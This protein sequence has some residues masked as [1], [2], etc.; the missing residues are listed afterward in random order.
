MIHLTIDDRQIQVAPGY[1]L[2][3]AA[4]E[5]N[6]PIPTLCSHE[7]LL[8]YGACRLCLVELVGSAGS[9]LVAS[10]TYPCQ[11]GLVV[12][13]NSDLVVSTRR[14]VVELLMATGMHLPI[15]RALAA[16][17]DIVAPYVS[18]QP[19]DCI[20][21]GLC[22][23]ACR[24]IVGVGAISLTHRGMERTVSTPFKIS[25]V[26]CIECGTCALVCPTGAIHVEDVTRP[27][28]TSHAWGSAYERRACHLCEC[29]PPGA[30]FPEDYQE[31]LGVSE[32]AGNRTR[33]DADKRG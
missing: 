8:P 3:Q 11:E 19:N 31:L 4:R 26:D 18:L 2:L 6:I 24:D 1:T 28:R 12:R 7:A 20:L 21:C 17:L 25:S 9:K 33:I 23:R 29:D 22:V 27:M 5:N 10:C 13:T 30:P 16:E 14:T 32:V 15:V